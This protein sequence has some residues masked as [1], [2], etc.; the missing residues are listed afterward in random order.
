LSRDEP[1]PGLVQTSGFSTG[2]SNGHSKY[3]SAVS[4]AQ[5][6]GLQLKLVY[7]DP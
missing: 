3:A 4:S 7:D 5:W 6:V 2:F 1:D